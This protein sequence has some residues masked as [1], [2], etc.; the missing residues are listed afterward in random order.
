MN[1]AGY[2]KPELLVLVPVL[3]AVG[4]GL[5]K[6][7]VVRDKFI[8]LILGIAGVLLSALWVAAT[9]VIPDAQSALMAVFVGLTQGVLCAAASVYVD[10]V[11]FKQPKRDD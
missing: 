10:Q 3:F 1:I 5:K 9:T 4:A 6:T 8:P 2:I 11:I 7:E